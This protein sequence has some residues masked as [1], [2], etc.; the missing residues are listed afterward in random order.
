MK[1]WI[2]ITIALRALRGNPLRSILTMLGIIIGVAAVITMVAIGAGAQM[3]IAERIRSLGANLI[4]ITPGSQSS[5]GVRYAAGTRH[6]LTES[7]SAAIARE[8]P[9]V[10]VVAP[11]VYGTTQVINGNRNWATTVV[12]GVPDHLVVR[13]WRVES[14]GSFSFAEVSSAAKVALLGSTVAEK[15]FEEDDPIGQQIR[16]R[17]VPFTVI[18]LLGSKGSDG[19]GRDQDDIIIIPLSTAKTRVLGGSHEVNRQAIGY[20]NVKVGHAGAM[21]AAER[22]IRQL[23]RQRHRLQGDAPDDFTITNMTEVLKARQATSRTLGILLAAVASVSLVVGGISIMNIMLVS[24]TER[25]REIGLRLAVG[26]RRRDLRGQFLVEAVTLSLLG[27]LIGS[28]LGCVAA[29]TIASS[30][31]WPVLITPGAILLAVGFAASVG[32]F[33]GFYPAHKASKLDPIEALR[34][35]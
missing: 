22:Q 26:A 19:R 4:I 25:T 6:T 7:D 2:N 23:L 35:E 30:A 13:D 1:T 24:V 17:E 15:L 27:G 8:I 33:F 5:E 12:G 14:G 9:V 3:Q 18:G 31:G 32:I 16:I 21:D 29:F 10:H 11:A 28:L 34:F 20:I